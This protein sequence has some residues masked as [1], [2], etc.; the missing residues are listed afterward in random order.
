[1]SNESIKPP[2]CSCLQH[3][4]QK[5]YL[6]CNHILTAKINKQPIKAEIQLPV[7]ENPISFGLLLCNASKHL[8]SQLRLICEQ[9]ALESGLL[10]VEVVNKQVARV[11]ED[12]LAS[13]ADWKVKS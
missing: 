8:P 10:Q 5:G 12:S 4:T 13:L 1:M 9:C 7:K 6:Y 3:G 2:Y 11:H